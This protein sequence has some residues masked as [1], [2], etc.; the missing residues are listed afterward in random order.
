MPTILVLLI[1]AFFAIIC[2]FGTIIYLDTITQVIKPPK[3]NHSEGSDEVTGAEAKATYHEDKETGEIKAQA[4]LSGPGTAQASAQ[5]GHDFHNNSAKQRTFIITLSFD[6]RTSVKIDAG[7]ANSKAIVEATAGAELHNFAENVQT[8]AGQQENPAGE[9]L[10]SAKQK[11]LVTVGPDKKIPVFLK[12]TAAAEASDEASEA[13]GSSE[14][15]GKV[16]EITFR[17]KMLF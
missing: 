15:M 4:S 17:P 2:V 10:A 11:F 1:A 5:M 3:L 7:A 9:G 13:T 6:Y 16:T 14:V 8:G 12:I